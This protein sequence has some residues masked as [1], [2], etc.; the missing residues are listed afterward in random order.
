MI[1]VMRTSSTGCKLI[2]IGVP[3]R[4]VSSPGAADEL[5]SAESAHSSWPIGSV[6]VNVEP[7]SQLALHRDPSA[8]Q[9][10]ELA[11]Q[12]QS[13]A[14]ALHL[15]VRRPHLAELLEDRLLILGL[16]ASPSVRDG[17]LG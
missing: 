15:H 7:S 4:P 6:N 8:M 3:L 11:G 14:G 1:V 12:G 5:T 17:D 9:L 10:N 13:K 2:V 16:D